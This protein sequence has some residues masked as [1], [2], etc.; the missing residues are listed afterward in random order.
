MSIRTMRYLGDP[1]LRMKCSPV[2]EITPGVLSL[3]DEMAEI[4]YDIPGIGLAA[5]QIGVNKRVIIFDIGE[6]LEVLINPEIISREDELE[7]QEGCL[8]IPDRELL[9]KRAQKITVRALNKEGEKKTFAFEGLIAR[10]VQ[11]EIDHL[12]GRLIVDTGRPVPESEEEN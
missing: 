11:H 8:S 9:V 2:K 6:G 10:V 1:V 3:I 4:M 5:P 12:D 7:S